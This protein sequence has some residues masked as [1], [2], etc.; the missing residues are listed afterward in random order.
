MFDENLRYFVDFYAEIDVIDFQ[1]NM[2]IK[3]WDDR[4]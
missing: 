4:G 3:D 2:E 1:R